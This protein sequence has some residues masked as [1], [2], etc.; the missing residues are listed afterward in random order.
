MAEPGWFESMDELTTTYPTMASSTMPPGPI[1]RDPSES[2]LARL[3][4]IAEDVPI[5]VD[6]LDELGRRFG[7]HVDGQL[8][9]TAPSAPMI[10]AV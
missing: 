5:I 9:N 4:M 8:A 10:C 6:D 1:Q 2:W 7:L 3:K